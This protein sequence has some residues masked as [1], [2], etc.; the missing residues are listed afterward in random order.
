MELHLPGRCSSSAKFVIHLANTVHQ[1]NVVLDN[2]GRMELALMHIRFL[3]THTGT[4]HS[5]F[6]RKEAVLREQAMGQQFWC[7]PGALKNHLMPE[8]FPPVLPGTNTVLP[9]EGEQYYSNL[10]VPEYFCLAG[11]AVL[12]NTQYFPSHFV[13]FLEV[14]STSPHILCWCPPL[15]A[16]SL[17]E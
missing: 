16:L 5:L 12:G 3:A 1:L 2:A 10:L 8:K 6:K 7:S 17:I 9:A 4:T 13:L 15:T 14:L 11:I